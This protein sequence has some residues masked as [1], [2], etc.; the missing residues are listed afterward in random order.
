MN[1]LPPLEQM[2]IVGTTTI[3]HDLPKRLSPVYLARGAEDSY[4]MTV[5]EAEP[6]R[7]VLSLEAAAHFD[8]LVAQGDAV[9]FGRTIAAREGHCLVQ[10]DEGASPE[11]FPVDELPDRLFRAQREA[12]ER[13]SRALA[14]GA[15]DEAEALA[16]YARRANGDDPLPV[17]LLCSL[18]RGA[19]PPEEL[20][21][22]EQDLEEYSSR[23]IH[24][25]R[26]RASEH[27]GLRAIGD[28]ID[29]P[30]NSGARPTYLDRFKSMPGF[31][32]LARQLISVPPRRRR[33]A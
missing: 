7:P 13:A 26:R 2:D 25:A 32:D 20:R 4:Y 6:R 16:W 18:L 24:A 3:S 29:E 11:Y 10:L 31:L 23:Q 28:L 12:L 27:P 9:R 5:S 30:P 15:R 21:Y 19:A 33:L 17:L 1:V 22:L 8:A 14:R